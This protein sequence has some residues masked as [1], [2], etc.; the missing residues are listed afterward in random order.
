MGRA[1]KL[2]NLRK[3][4]NNIEKEARMTIA[5]APKV[6]WWHNLP[7]IGEWLYM[8]KV[9]PWWSENLLKSVAIEKASRRTYQKN[10]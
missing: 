5:H 6:M 9:K 2:K 4:V 8:R 10:K 1:K 7:L 3:Q